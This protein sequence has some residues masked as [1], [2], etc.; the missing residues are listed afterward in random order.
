MMFY[1][2]WFPPSA[3]GHVFPSA[4]FALKQAPNTY[5]CKKNGKAHPLQTW[6]GFEDSRR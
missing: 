4:T 1:K 3:Q 6:I 2:F 5:T